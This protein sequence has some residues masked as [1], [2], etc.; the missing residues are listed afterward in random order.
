MTD[1]PAFRELRLTSPFMKS[2]LVELVQKA[3]GDGLAIDGEYGPATAAS[4][5][6][7]QWRL[8]ASKANGILT[9]IQIRYLLGF[10]PFPAGWKARA[11]KR[12]GTEPPAAP[13]VPETLVIAGD[14]PERAVARMEQWAN[15]GVME[16]PA[17]A[18]QVPALAT[19]CKQLG[20]SS[21]Y[22]KMGWPWCCHAGFLPALEAGGVSAKAGYAGKFNVLYTVSI[23][24][25]AQAALHGMRIVGRSQARRGDIG[26]I[27]FPKGDPRVDHF[28]RLREAPTSSMVKTVEGNTSSGRAGSQDNGGMMALR[29]RPIDIFRAYIRD[30]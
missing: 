5:T 25:T 27:N 18:N 8:G 24:D 9:P 1:R 28:A 19:L 12:V 14:V 13:A 29:E 20:L 4:A 21:W 3:L 2:K 7:W 6:G 11:A 23:L 17:G 26:L 16:R 30:S 22:Q 15:E 10:R